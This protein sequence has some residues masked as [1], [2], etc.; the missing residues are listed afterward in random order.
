MRHPRTRRAHATSSTLP[1]TSGLPLNGT[2]CDCGCDARD[3]LRTGRDACDT[4]CAP[5]DSVRITPTTDATPPTARP[6]PITE[7][8]S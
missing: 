7:D 4:R 8:T 1:L 5:R 6:P 3:G 2:S